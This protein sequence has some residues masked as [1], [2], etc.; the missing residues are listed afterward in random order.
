MHAAPYTGVLAWPDDPFD[1]EVAVEL[2]DGRTLAVKVDRPLG[3]TAAVPIP[4][5]L[6]QAKFEDC[7]AQ[8]VGRAA[9]AAAARR[10]ETLEE[11]ASLR[12]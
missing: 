4:Y 9:A 7:A 6:L 5:P 8:V 10:I 12:D 2:A 3:R 1:A 11:L